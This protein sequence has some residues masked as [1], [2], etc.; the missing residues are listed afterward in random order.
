VTFSCNRIAS[1]LW[2]GS[3]PPCGSY[4]NFQTIVLAAKEY[5]LHA[6]Q[7]PGSKVV[8][9]PLDDNALGMQPYE[10]RLIENAS[11]ECWADWRQ[12]K[13]ILVTCAMGLNRSGVVMARTLM[14]CFRWDAETAIRCVQAGRPGA[15]Y[16]RH[17]VAWLKSKD[18]G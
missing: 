7:L 16:N 10:G 2:Q 9:A 15:L 8:Y 3:A 18:V 4:P 14:R 13:R 17:F 5:Q 6:R 11:F 1:R 12:G